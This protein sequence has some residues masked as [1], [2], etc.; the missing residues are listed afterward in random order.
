[1]LLRD[2]EAVQSTVGRARA[3]HGAARAYL[4]H[5]M[6]DLIAALEIGRDHLVS[7]RAMLRISF[8]HAAESAIRIVQMLE[9]DLGALSIFETFP[10][11]RAGR[12]INGA[13]KHIAM[14]TGLYALAGRL[15][16]GLEPNS[17]R[18]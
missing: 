7:S 2:R 8:A 10:M 9:S 14:N 3:L 15:E 1:M 4:V 5:T 6:T 11:E 18:F 13:A 16:L 12:D 17:E